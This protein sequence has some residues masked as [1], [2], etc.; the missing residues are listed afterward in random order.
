M[1]EPAARS[2]A[3]SWRRLDTW[4]PLIVALLAYGIGAVLLFRH[5]NHF[6]GDEPHYML[7]AHSL[8]YDHDADLRNNYEAQDY[9]EFYPRSELDA[10]AY[11]YRGNGALRS[12]HNIGLPVL[13]VLPYC[14]LGHPYWARLE[15]AALAA[16]ASWSIF[17]MIRDWTGRIWLAYATWAA[18]A[19][20]VPLWTLAPQLYPD[21]V[22]VLGVAVALQ[23][24]TSRSLT[25]GKALGIGI[26]VAVLPWLHNRFVVLSVLITLTTV[27]SLLR[28]RT[29]WKTYLLL[30][31]PPAISG[32][33][34][35]WNSY[36]WYGG[37]LP[38]A[39]YELWSQNVQHLTLNRLYVALADLALGREFGLLPYA[40]VYAVALVGSVMMILHRRTVFLAPL[41]WLIGYVLAVAL[42]QATYQ[43]GWGYYFPA[44]LLLPITPLLAL[45]LAYSLQ[46]SR[47]LRIAGL[48]LFVVSVA[49]SVQS[50][51]QPYRAL[52]DQNGVSELPLLRRI[53][54]IFPALQYIQQS[55]ELDISRMQ[56]DTGQLT[57]DQAIDSQVI[58]AQP[59]VDP[60]GYMAFG[61]YVAFQTG[62]YAA[63]FTL[64]AGEAD[65]AATVAHIEVVTDQGQRVLAERDVYAREFIADQE[66]RAF[67]LSVFTR[68]TWA[69]EFRVYF[70]GEST[71][72]LR[73]IDVKPEKEVAFDPYPGLPIV[74]AWSLGVIIAGLL[75]AGKRELPDTGLISDEGRMD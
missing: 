54:G 26:V 1:Q 38:S 29:G 73:S 37:V 16:L 71:L 52:A 10:H 36:V 59:E 20:T 34:W 46:H 67:V 61:R 63:A 31:F 48:A 43:I 35:M 60:A 6:D 12:I 41:I 28:S 17:L 13:L 2:Q 69:L 40:P 57:H 19:L 3:A 53:Q 22:A 72:W 15:M 74:A 30:L 27:A 47:W 32:L 23:L 8:C 49:I 39:S 5:L 42:S 56:R 45:P 33:L 50:L 51:A 44:R 14:I 64:G 11:D 21:V 55:A 65:P 58:L 25:G 66:S 18:L 4:V 62:Q 24:F 9:L 70:T 75:A 7:M 68:D